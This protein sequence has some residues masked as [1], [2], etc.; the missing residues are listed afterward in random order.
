[1]ALTLG[2]TMPELAFAVAVADALTE[3]NADAAV[4]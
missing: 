2:L 3:G 4:P 1:M